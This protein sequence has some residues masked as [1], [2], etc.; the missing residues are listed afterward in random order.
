MPFEIV[1]LLRVAASVAAK[2]QASRS[3]ARMPVVGGDGVDGT[4]GASA[5]GVRPAA[6]PPAIVVSRTKG[7][8][9]DEFASLNGLLTIVD[10]A[11]PDA[12]VSRSGIDVRQTDI[13]CLPRPGGVRR[14]TGPR[15]APP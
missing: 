8:D 5:A 12:S 9:G 3:S 15:L 4:D 10:I 11:P 6:G 7:E 14:S 13:V 2:S 1:D